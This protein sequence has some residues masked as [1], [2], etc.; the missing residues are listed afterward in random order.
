MNAPAPYPHLVRREQADAAQGTFSHPW[1][2]RSEIT[3][4]RLSQLG[5][6]Q[7]TGVS[8]ARLA[9]GKESFAYHLHHQEEEWVYVL[10]GRAVALIDGH[11]YTLGPGDFVAFPTPSVAHLMSNPGPDELVYLM[12]G[13]NKPHEV[14]DFPTLGKRMVKTGGKVAVYNLSD[15][16]RLDG[17][18]AA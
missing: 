7:R 2:P 5:G 12:G 14:A 6:L 4:T 11:E 8:L 16:K 17:S 15:G 3:G 18:P 9:P 1:N 13:E 10:S